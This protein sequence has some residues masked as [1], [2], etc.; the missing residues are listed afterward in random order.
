MPSPTS[1]E[2]GFVLTGKTV[3]SRL[4]TGNRKADNSPFC[5]RI[6]MISTGSQ[7]YTYTESLDPTSN[8]KTLSLDKEI[9]VTDITNTRTEN[10][11][12]TIN[13]THTLK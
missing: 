13:G 9:Q 10:N 11:I 12:I 5:I 7:V 1:N 3:A 8:P 6:S 2:Y 4:Q